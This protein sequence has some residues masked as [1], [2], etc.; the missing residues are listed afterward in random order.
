MIY[1][2]EIIILAIQMF[3]YL[4]DPHFYEK[5]SYGIEKMKLFH[6]HGYKYIREMQGPTDMFLIRRPS[7]EIGTIKKDLIRELKE[8]A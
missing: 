3:M 5:T 4:Y 1:I 2:K 8:K 7:E 6:A